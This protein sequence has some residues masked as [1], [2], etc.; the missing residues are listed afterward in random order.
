MM[1]MIAN[2]ENNIKE[3][4]EKEMIEEYKSM[5]QMELLALKV[6]FKEILTLTTDELVINALRNHQRVE[7][8]AWEIIQ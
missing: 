8:V 3:L 1:K 5:L 4:R 7:D 6:P 2:N